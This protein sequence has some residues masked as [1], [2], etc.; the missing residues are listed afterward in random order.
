MV[1]YLQE[2][3]QAQGITGP[4]A[5]EWPLVVT[6]APQTGSCT[7]ELAKVILA[8]KSCRLLVDPFEWPKVKA[9]TEF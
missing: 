7:G 4:A 3:L 5:G 1:G 6:V 9:S 2:Y 8:A